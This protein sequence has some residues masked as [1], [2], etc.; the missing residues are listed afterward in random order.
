MHGDVSLEGVETNYVPKLRGKVLKAKNVRKQ[1]IDTKIRKKFSV[2]E[3]RVQ[4]AKRVEGEPRS[5][6]LGSPLRH[7]FPSHGKLNS[8]MSGVCETVRTHVLNLSSF[9]AQCC[10]CLLAFCCCHC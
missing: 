4:K 5:Y 9:I 7:Q 10:W 6:P 3:D 1:G 8:I 2:K